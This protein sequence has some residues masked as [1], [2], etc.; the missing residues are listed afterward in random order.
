MEHAYLIMALADP[1]QLH[2]LIKS[3]E[4]TGVTFFVHIDSKAAFDEKYVE[5]KQPIFA[6]IYFI[7]VKNAIN[8]GNFYTINVTP[9]TNNF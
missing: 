8:W 7:E 2:N 9:I 5:D 4:A 1:D 6:D 3:P